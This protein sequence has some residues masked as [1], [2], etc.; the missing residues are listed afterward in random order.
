MDEN[1]RLYIERSN[2]LVTRGIFSD[3]SELSD[4]SEFKILG[5]YSQW[6]KQ[7]TCK[8]FTITPYVNKTWWIRKILK[9][10]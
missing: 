9:A 7:I 6:P 5:R 2:V 8:K 3:V 4:I 10:A 1:Y